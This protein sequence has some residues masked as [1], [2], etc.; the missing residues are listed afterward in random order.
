MFPMTELLGIGGK[1]IDKLIPDPEA[2]AKAQLELA[3]LAQEGELARMANEVADLDSARKREMAVATSENA[4]YLNKI[5]VPVLAIS[6]LTATFALFGLVLF[7]DG[8]IDPTRKDIII[9]VL[10]VLSA[11]ST[12]IVAYYFGSSKGSADKTTSIDK[13]LTK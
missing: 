10:G 7:S 6:I 8:V 11:I 2:K 5:I 9:Y 1:L 13:I 3:K 4:P 12:Q